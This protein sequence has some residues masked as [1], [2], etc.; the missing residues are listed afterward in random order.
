MGACPR[1]APPRNF[2]VAPRALFATPCRCLASCC[3]WVRY[4]RA[5][6]SGHGSWHRASRPRSTHAPPSCATQAAA[7]PAQLRRPG[8]GI[9]CLR[10]PSCGSNLLARAAQEKALA[11]GAVGGAPATRLTHHAALPPSR[12]FSQPH[13]PPLSCVRARVSSAPLPLFSHCLRFAPAFLLRFF[14]LGGL[15]R[16]SVLGPPCPL[17]HQNCAGKGASAPLGP[18]TLLPLSQPL[19]SSA[20]PRCRVCVVARVSATRLFLF[21]RCLRFALVFLLLFFL[22]GGLFR[23]PVLLSPWALASAPPPLLQGW[24]LWVSFRAAAAA[25]T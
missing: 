13:P 24:P 12:P 8:C 18:A 16:V 6:R 4:R 21:S 20:R 5:S 1:W 9:P 25:G 22:L 11:A 3:A 10:H 2:G 19:P 7:Y 15:F 23:V 17:L 14:L